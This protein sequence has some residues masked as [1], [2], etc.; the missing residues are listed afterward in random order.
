MRP[1]PALILFAVGLVVLLGG[2][3]LGPGSVPSG[4]RGTATGRLLF[5][6]LATR[7]PGAARVEIM[8]G[9]KT[10][11]LIDKDGTWGVAER[12]FYPAQQGK[13]RELLTGLTELRLQEPRTRNPAQ[14]A[15][16]GVE[17]PGAE[18]AGSTLVRVLDGG[19]RPLAELIVGHRRTRLQGDSPDTLYVRLP[20][21]PQSWLAEGRLAVD[22]DPLLWLDRDLM[23]IDGK[24]VAS[25]S[26]TRP[27][28]TLVFGRKDDKLALE[29]PT[30]TPPLDPF[31][32]ENVGHALEHLSLQD[33]RPASGAPPTQPAR[34]TFTTEDGLVVTATVW[35]DG[36][37]VWARFGATGTDKTQA[38]ADGLNA[39][40]AAWD[41]QIGDWT[42]KSLAPRLDDLEAATPKAE[43]AP[44]SAPGAWP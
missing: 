3:V 1:H 30:G 26:V 13:L 11:A 22:T 5:P 17:D 28:G 39:R 9:G 44:A 27:G 38:E 4:Q 43:T 7:L 18:A 40:L 14:L 16:L 24:R 25:V 19:G 20:S 29:Q 34:A 10:L 35:P 41:Y 23:S 12:A 8:H 31:K 15:R 33:V 32:V 36:K 37:Q 21:D 2:W 42:A 6:D